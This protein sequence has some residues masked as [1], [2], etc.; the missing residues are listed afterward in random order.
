M[1]DFI[2]KILDITMLLLSIIALTVATGILLTLVIRLP[3]LGVIFQVFVLISIICFYTQRK[4][5]E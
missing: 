5:D 3:V 2:D 1:D 4:P